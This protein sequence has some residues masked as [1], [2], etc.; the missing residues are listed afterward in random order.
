MIRH[1]FDPEAAPAQ[2]SVPPHLVIAGSAG[3]ALLLLLVA[4]VV[5]FKGP[6]Q[7][8]LAATRVAEA[9]ADLDRRFQDAAK[10]SANLRNEQQVSF[11]RLTSHRSELLDLSEEAARVNRPEVAQ[12]AEDLAN[13][14]ELRE[15]LGRAQAELLRATQDRLE[16][17]NERGL[18][19]V[20]RV[21]KRLPSGFKDAERRWWKTQ[22]Q[23][24]ETWTSFHRDVSAFL[25]TAKGETA[26][27]SELTRARELQRR[28]QQEKLSAT[29]DAY[30]LVDWLKAQ[31]KLG[32]VVLRREVELREAGRHRE[33]QEARQ[34]LESL[35]EDLGGFLTEHPREAGRLLGVHPPN[36]LPDFMSS[37]LGE[38]IWEVLVLGDWYPPLERAKATD[39]PE[40]FGLVPRRKWSEVPPARLFARLAKLETTVRLRCT[41]SLS[42]A[43]I[44]RF[45]KAQ[46]RTLVR[47]WPERFQD[48]ILRLLP[49]AVQREVRPEAAKA[50][51]PPLGVASSIG[52]G[53]FVTKRHLLT[54]GHVVGTAKEV[55]VETADGVQTGKVIAVSAAEDLALIEVAR[56]GVPLVAAETHNLRMVFA[57]GY[58]SLSGQANT[59]LSTGGRVAAVAQGMGRVIFSAHVNPGNS[60]GPLVDAE[61]RWVGVVVAKSVRTSAA[62]DS[63]G[64]AIHGDRALA[65][66]SA[67]GIRLRAAAPSISDETPPDA[68]V[69]RSVARIVA[70]H[71]AHESPAATS[72]A[73]TPKAALEV[74]LQVLCRLADAEALDRVLDLEAILADLQTRNP[75][76][77]GLT[78]AGLAAGFKAELRKKE[79]RGL[80]QAEVSGLLAASKTELR[81]E[82]A[83]IT[84]PGPLEYRFRESREGWLITYFPH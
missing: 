66:L 40:L 50:D 64:I 41:L 52:T 72:G 25:A 16:R 35:E 14:S 12:R 7:D 60:G 3:F 55:R 43:C 47:D 48:L 84:L 6:S 70:T 63:L 28:A 29:S 4:L 21:L 33:A 5:I 49:P 74:Y 31:S 71:P 20:T 77:K 34:V 19:A 30:A 15:R 45:S 62:E 22:S 80:T 44:R 69:R 54:N 56:G 10:R 76:A 39:L 38:G 67:Q 83:T 58:G 46:I 24:L 51:V 82:R 9:R 78:T 57:Y 13:S 27:L 81:G 11:E 65:W 42:V 36:G 1:P 2:E 18:A 23:R 75:D 61:G 26:G 17:A 32:V 68:Q 79:S 73:S 8:P 37:Y 53:F 59:L